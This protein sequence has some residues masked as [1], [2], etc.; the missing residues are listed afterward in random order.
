MLDE[1][2][3]P[4]NVRL[5]LT[6]NG[7]TFVPV[8]QAHLTAQRRIANQIE[9]RLPGWLPVGEFKVVPAREGY[10]PEPD[11][12]ALPVDQFDPAKSEFD[13]SLLPFVVEVVSPESK[14]RDYNSKS[15]HYALRGIPAYLV[16]NVLTARWTLL[17]QPENGEYQHT[18]SGAFGQEIEIPVAGQ[19]L[20]LDSAQF[21][22]V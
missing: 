1:I 5:R 8:T 17:T 19:T 13:E 6:R 14:N 10:K 7:L 9:E 15:D 20:T 16:V 3:L 18:V 11:A 22:R 4:R 21:M 2:Q 12:S